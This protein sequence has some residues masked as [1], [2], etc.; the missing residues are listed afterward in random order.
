MIEILD[1]SEHSKNSPVSGQIAPSASGQPPQSWRTLSVT[2]IWRGVSW[3]FEKRTGSSDSSP[4]NS[5]GSLHVAA[6]LLSCTLC[7]DLLRGPVRPVLHHGDGGPHDVAHLA[8]PGHQ[9]Q[10]SRVRSGERR[11][12]AETSQQQQQPHPLPTQ[13][14]DRLQWLWMAHLTDYNYT[15]HI[16]TWISPTCSCVQSEF[17]QPTEWTWSWTRAPAPRVCGVVSLQGEICWQLQGAQILY[18]CT[19]FVVVM[20][21]YFRCISLSIPYPGIWNFWAWTWAWLFVCS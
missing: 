16:V 13:Y 14:Y 10:V 21:R 18:V 8:I 9:H 11:G 17:R 1:Q 7:T 6:C 2:S 12:Q 19:K 4:P 15:C 20:A 5:N 3:F